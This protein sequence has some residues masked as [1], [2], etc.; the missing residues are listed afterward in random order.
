M[1]NVIKLFFLL[2]L[3]AQNSAFAVATIAQTKNKYQQESKNR[4]ALDAYA[5]IIEARQRNIHPLVVLR[6]NGYNSI[7]GVPTD[8]KTLINFL[9]LNRSWIIDLRREHR[10][11]DLRDYQ[12]TSTYF[13]KLANGS[14]YKYQTRPEVDLAFN[15]ISFLQL[16]RYLSLFEGALFDIEWSGKYGVA[17]KELG[18]KPNYM[19]SNELVVSLASRLVENPDMWSRYGSDQSFEGTLGKFAILEYLAGKSGVEKKLRVHLI[20]SL[21]DGEFMNLDLY[22]KHP[23]FVKRFFKVIS[24]MHKDSLLINKILRQYLERYPRR[25]HD[26]IEELDASKNKKQIKGFAK[27]LFSAKGKYIPRIQAKFLDR[28]QYFNSVEEIVTKSLKKLHG[29]IPE[30]LMPYLLKYRRGGKF[31][32]RCVLS[33]RRRSL[34]ILKK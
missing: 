13:N 20:S 22:L 2:V 32:A 14:M 30:D 4:T 27:V 25:A 6:T 7:F 3:L 34:S 31:G 28:L 15:E 12:A 19:F 23:A 29:E 33:F 9:D 24:T 1:L 18:A 11:I 21:S 16:F 17:G 26:F 10:K 5:D 8:R